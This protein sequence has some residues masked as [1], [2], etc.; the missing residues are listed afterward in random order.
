MKTCTHLLP[1]AKMT[2]CYANVALLE[3]SYTGD[4]CARGPADCEN[5]LLEPPSVTPF[6]KM[7]NRLVAEAAA[8]LSD[9]LLGQSTFPRNDGVLWSPRKRSCNLCLI[10]LIEFAQ[11]Y[12]QFITV[13]FLTDDSISQYHLPT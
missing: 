5:R 1:R 8:S 9:L 7:L 12:M 13:I 10:R 3:P 11:H 4:N 2:H 6:V